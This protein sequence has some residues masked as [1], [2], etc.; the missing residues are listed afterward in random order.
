[1]D[2]RADCDGEYR[3]S[4]TPLRYHPVDVWDAE[5]TDIRRALAAL[6]NDEPPLALPPRETIIG[7]PLGLSRDYDHLPQTGPLHL[8]RC[9]AC[10]R[11]HE[12]ALRQASDGCRI[13][14]CMCQTCREKGRARWIAENRVE[15]PRAVARYL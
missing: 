2:S 5:S 11:L 3:V 9:Q 15:L 10:E 12:D 1:M 14:A 6:V 13:L 4:H 7:V 8:V